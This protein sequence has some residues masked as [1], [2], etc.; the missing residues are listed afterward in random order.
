M[1]DITFAVVD[2]TPEPYAG[3]P[4]L[5]ARVGIASV[6]DVHA[7][8]LRCQVRIE[9]SRRQYS[10][11]EGAELVDLFGPRNRWAA[12][13]HSFLWQHAA[14]MVPGFTGTT[15]VQLPL[16]CTYDFEVAASKYLHALRDGAIPLQFLF[17]GTVFERGSNGFTVQQVPWDRE[18]RY[19]MPVSVWRDLI[20]QHFPNTGWLRLHRDTIDALAAYRSARGLLGFDEA[21]ASLLAQNSAARELS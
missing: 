10:D 14:A 13:Q 18:E 15:Q 4:I 1:T 21:I 9:P 16:E 12:T 7:I 2:V 5:M 20:R 19:D 17:S 8:A 6:A 3:T 11:D